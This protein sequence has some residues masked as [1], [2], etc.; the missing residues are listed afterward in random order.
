MSEF[1]AYLQLGFDHMTDSNGYDHLLFIMALCTT[2]TLVDYKKVIVLVTAF[3]IGH[4][5][6]LVLSTL[7]IIHFQPSLIELLIPITILVTTFIN[8]FHKKEEFSF[9]KK[10]KKNHF[11]YVLALVFGLIHGLGF[12]NYLHMLLG[13][14][15]NIITPLL[16]FNIGL[17]IGQLL[18]VLILLIVSFI[19]IELLRIPKATWNYI[20]SGIITGMA[21]SLIIQNNLLHEL[22]SKTPN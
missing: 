11:R 22:I 20:V 4:S 6:T 13:Q 16:G 10:Q 17:E 19:G 8:F 12:S 5:A 21:I 1:L 9:R 14:E 18:I 2:F 7:D 15:A 3:T